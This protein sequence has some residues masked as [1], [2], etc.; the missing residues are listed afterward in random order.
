MRSSNAMKAQR[1]SSLL[2]VIVALAIL[3]LAASGALSGLLTANKDL[4]QGQLRQYKMALVDAT[5]QR[6]LLADK[7]Q[8]QARAVALPATPPAQ[9]AIGAAPWGPDTT[10]VVPGDLSTGAYF[11]VRPDGEI[12]QIT[13][14]P[15]GTKCNAA[16]LPEGSY[17]REVLLTTGMPV[18]LGTHSAVLPTTALPLTY[19]VRVARKGE[20]PIT[21]VVHRKVIVQ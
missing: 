5:M 12:T 8:L 1:G 2:E 10:S 3:A 6:M 4:R 21:A 15:A 14:I 20:V 11:W 16:A 17:C 7:T 13:G 19:W 9:L 18:A